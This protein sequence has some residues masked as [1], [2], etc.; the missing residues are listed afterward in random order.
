MDAIIQTMDER[1]QDILTGI[2][3]GD[4]VRALWGSTDKLI[5]YTGIIRKC[6]Q[7]ALFLE[8]EDG[9][10]Q[11]VPLDALF[12]NVERIKADNSNKEPIHRP[13]PNE[14]K[15]VVVFRNLRQMAPL[16]PAVPYH[17]DAQV[18]IDRIRMM[19]KKSDNVPLKQNIHAILDSLISSIKDR[20]MGYKYHNLRAKL[21]M[22][23]EICNSDIDYEIFYLLMGVLAVCA[24]DY[25][26]ALEPLVRAGRYTLAAYSA[27]MDQNSG[28]AGIF[29]VCA[30]LA[31]EP[32]AVFNQFI[33]EI[34][35]DRHDS[36]VLELLLRQN[37]NNIDI[38]ESIASCAYYMYQQSN[39]KL[40]SDI[41]PYF[42]AVQAATALL[43]AIPVG[44]KKES[45][46]KKRWAEFQQYHYPEVVCDPQDAMPKIHAGEI[47]EFVKG[48]GKNYGRISPNVFFHVRQISDSTE[49]GRLLRK[50]LASGLG[51]G[52][53]VSYIWGESW[54]LANKVAATNIDL[55]PKGYQNALRLVESGAKIDKYQKGFV[56]FYDAHREQGM[57]Q[58]GGKKYKFR[59]S[60]IADP[61]LKAYYQQ[62]FSTREQDVSFELNGKTAYNICWENPLQSDWEAYAQTVTAGMREAWENFRQNRLEEESGLSLSERD[63]FEKYPCIELRPW[64]PKATIRP[65][66]LTWENRLHRTN[67]V[68]ESPKNELVE[69]VVPVRNLALEAKAYADRAR[70]DMVDGQYDRAEEEF[71][72]ALQYGGFNFGLVSDYITLFMQQPD[73]I[74]RAVEILERFANLFP[75]EK[76]LNIRIQ[77]YDKMKDN[78]YRLL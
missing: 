23:W 77:V 42:S 55:T 18:W 46:I 29:S 13:D 63:P 8:M 6:T 21:H 52:L 61:Y 34:C 39:G 1:I 62:A 65:P 43:K 57:I 11:R 48:E 71:E 15:P 17:F 44:W 75:S 66:A 47:T 74:H 53:E 51:K 64:Q 37:Q 49:S 22:Q 31:E 32:G 12:R 25:A 69:P 24:E 56:E 54:S 72:K 5:A 59:L 14:I 73:K 26:Y 60:G 7:Y 76:L 10:Q 30:L 45:E 16:H 67:T 50:L 70:K 41:T 3:L 9:E 36:D 78:G 4:R 35:I 58:S 20:S 68:K 28:D 2:N 19:V 33:S 27:S 38:C 40:A